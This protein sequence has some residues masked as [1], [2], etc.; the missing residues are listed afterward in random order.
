MP[1]AA[2]ELQIVARNFSPSNPPF[3]R[4]NSNHSFDPQMDSGGPVLWE[5][6][7]TRLTVLTGIISYGDV[8]GVSAGVNTRVGAFVDWVTSVT[9][10]KCPSRGDTQNPEATLA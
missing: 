9:A 3:D 2:E 10:G 8:C 6:P 1:R 4:A 5:N 7:T